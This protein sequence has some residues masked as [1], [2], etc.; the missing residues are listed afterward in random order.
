MGQSVYPV[1]TT[2]QVSVIPPVHVLSLSAYR[3]LFFSLSL[4]APSPQNQPII[5]TIN[6]RLWWLMQ[7]NKLIG[8]LNS[9][10]SLVPCLLR[11]RMRRSESWRRDEPGDGEAEIWQGIRGPLDTTGRDICREMRDSLFF[12]S[13][14]WLTLAMDGESHW[15][16]YKIAEI[17]CWIGWVI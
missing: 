14:L 17:G 15:I 1:I 11:A 5:S 8:T 3:S 6:V 10:D 16:R 13:T 7:L 9:H 2:A 4:S 12:L